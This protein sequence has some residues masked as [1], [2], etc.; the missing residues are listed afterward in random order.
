MFLLYLLESRA[1]FVLLVSK[2]IDLVYELV[3]SL[4][5]VLDIRSVVLLESVFCDNALQI[6]DD[7]LQ[8]YHLTL[9]QDSL[10]LEFD[11]QT[12]MSLLQSLQLV[13]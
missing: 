3:Y 9:G 13:M 10:F 5:D 2:V 11:A 12:L 8:I 4:S 6:V 7:I 1:D